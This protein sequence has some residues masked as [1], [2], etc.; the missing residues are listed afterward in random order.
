MINPKLAPLVKQ[1][2]QKMVEA[3]IIAPIRYSEWLSNP[4]PTADTIAGVL[5]QK[6]EK[7]EEQPIAFMSK[8]LSSAKA[9]YH[10]M[11]K[12]AY[13]LVMFLKHF[14]VYIGYSEIMAYVPH[15]AVK[16]ILKQQDDLDAQAKWITKIQEYDLE[17][18]PTK[19]IK[20]RGLAQL[21]AEGKERHWT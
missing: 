8:A 3:K 4:I 5:L 11:E 7:N 18:Q 2:L 1:E 12:Q 21:L 9:K 13:A 14:R 17:I 19:L 6:N 15:P 10:S 20:D 16:E